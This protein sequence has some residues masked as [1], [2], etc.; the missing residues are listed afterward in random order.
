MRLRRARRGNVAMLT[1]LL[2]VPLTG[3]V[4]LAI[5]F[6]NAT[7][8]RARLDAAADAAALLA[9]TVA[10]NQYLAGVA[11]PTG[12]AQTAAAARFAAMAGAQANVALGPP[13]ISV[14]QSGS[15]FNASVTYTGIYRTYL[16]AVVGVGSIALGGVSAASLSVNPY[17][18]IQVL[19]DVSSSMTIAATPSDIPVPT[20]AATP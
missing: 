5:D 18:D 20:P 9:T 3:M 10:S 15:L 17:V 4:A 13:L 2:A 12:T 16:G 8:A 11:N 14:T 1:A 19:M 6:G 7:A